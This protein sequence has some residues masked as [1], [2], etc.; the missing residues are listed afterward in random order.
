MGAVVDLLG[1][2]VYGMG[3]VDRLLQLTPGTARR[4]IDG[5]ARGGR[6][7][8]PV[9]R[10]EPTGEDI[11]TWGEFVETRLLAGYR[12]QN[13]RIQHMRPAVERLREELNTPYP[14]AHAAPFLRV[15]GRE[16]VREVQD[17]VGLE[18]SLSI[19]VV[20]NGQ[21]MLSGPAQQ[22]VDSVE[23]T[24]DDHGVVHLYRP[25]PLVPEV[26]CEP[27][28]RFGAPA[29]G[30]ISTEILAEQVWAGDPPE[31][32]AEIYSLTVEQVNAAV[33]FE[34]RNAA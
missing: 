31:F 7:Y 6:A 21:I 8:P 17:E 20:R 19:V 24:D 1:R 29:V 5:Y 15:S 3:Q 11:V 2:R 12:S 14:L 4:W 9:V 33:R 25:D 32:V 16:L 34:A 18:R 27:Q 23:F 26:V 28:R 13:V 22:F 30:G 10:L